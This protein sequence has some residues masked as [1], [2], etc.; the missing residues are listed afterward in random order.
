MCADENAPTTASSSK[1]NN[2]NFNQNSIIFSS[3][4]NEDLVET[5]QTTKP[6]ISDNSNKFTKNKLVK[7][8]GMQTIVTKICMLNKLFKIFLSDSSFAKAILQQYTLTWQQF[9]E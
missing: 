1:I 3:N 6:I 4:N 5:C 9:G 7:N 2:T 8:I